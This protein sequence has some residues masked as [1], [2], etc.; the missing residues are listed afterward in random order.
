M[1]FEV[2]SIHALPASSGSIG[3][4]L[5]W[6]SPI[7]HEPALMKQS[8]AEF[9][10]VLGTGGKL[11]VGFFTG[12]NVERFDHAITTAHTWPPDAMAAELRASGFEIIETHTRTG[13]T[14]KPRPHGAILAHLSADR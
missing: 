5:A 1:P 11:L 9:A 13:A 7:H 4:V 12:P 3:G 2:A 14:P 8:L 10:R 6:Y